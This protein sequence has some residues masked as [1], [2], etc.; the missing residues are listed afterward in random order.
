MAKIAELVEIKTGYAN[1]V[2]LV[3]EFNDPDDNRGRMT[4]YMPIQSHRVTFDQIS[5]MLLPLDNRVYLLLGSYGTGKSHLCLMLANYLSRNTAEPEIQAFLAN[6][7]ASQKRSQ[8]QIG[9]QASEEA[10]A[11]TIRNRRGDGRFLVA[12]AEYGAGDDFDTL[13]L[14]AIER[15]CRREGFTGFLDTH[16]NEAVRRLERWQ[17]ARGDRRA[18]RRVSR[19]P[20]PVEPALSRTHPGR[21]KGGLGELPTRGPPHLQGALPRGG[22]CGLHLPRGQPGAHPAGLSRQSGVQGALPRAGH[23]RR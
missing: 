14:R 10:S 3:Q 15:A 19:L 18:V 16:Y 8:G 23:H 1:Y 7:E 12:L 2:N 9:V 6:W 20:G 5:R 22:G 11:E 13:V 4:Q 21:A 17:A